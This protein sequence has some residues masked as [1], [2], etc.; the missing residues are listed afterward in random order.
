MAIGRTGAGR[1]TTEWRAAML[2]SAGATTKHRV[3]GSGAGT[4][5]LLA[6]DDSKTVT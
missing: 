5:S 2:L 6:N 1:T 3:E 4:W